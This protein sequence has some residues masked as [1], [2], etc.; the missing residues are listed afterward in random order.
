MRCLRSKKSR[1]NMLH[2][3][4][5]HEVSRGSAHIE[6]VLW[7]IFFRFPKQV[8]KSFDIYGVASEGITEV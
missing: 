3:E 8:A 4:L 2:G 6:D 1:A 7:T 5:L